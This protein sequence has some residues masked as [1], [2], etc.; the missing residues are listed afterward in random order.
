MFNLSSAFFWIARKPDLFY[1]YSVK[2]TLD[3]PNDLYREAKATAA[4][5]RI[6]MKDL[7]TEGLRMALEERKRAMGRI[8]PLEALREIRLRPLHSPAGVAR[9]IEDQ[10]ALRQAGWNRTDS[11][12]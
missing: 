12:E 3:I 9:M 11:Q 2:T 4:I 1:R 8:S 5:E 6:K 10:A 7:V